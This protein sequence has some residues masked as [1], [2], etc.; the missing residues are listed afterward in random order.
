MA[1]STR[2]K[3]ISIAAGA[4]SI[5]LVAPFVS[6]STSDLPAAHAQTVATQASDFD[7]PEEVNFWDTDSVQLKDLALNPGDKVET[8]YSWTTV[9]TYR[10]KVTADELGVLTVGRPS[11][12]LAFSSKVGKTVEIPVKVTPI[13]GDPYEATLKIAVKDEKPAEETTTSESSEPEAPADPSAAPSEPS[14]APSEPSAA[15]S[16]SSEPEAPAESEGPSTSEKAPAPE[17]PKLDFDKTY[18][19]EN[20]WNKETVAVPDAKLQP[21]DKIAST[22]WDSTT[23]WPVEVDAEGNV[24]IGKPWNKITFNNAIKAGS[25]DIPVT[26]TPKEGEPYS[27]TLKVKLTDTMPP[28]EWEGDLPDFSKIYSV[29]FEKQ[30]V[31][32]VPGLTLPTNVTIE[33]SGAKYPLWSFTNVNGEVQVNAPATFTPGVFDLPVKISDGTSTVE[34]TIRINATNPQT[35]GG[36]IAKGIGG[37]LGPILGGLIGGGT[38]GLG[39]TLGNLLGGLLGGGSGGSGGSGDGKGGSGGGLLGNLKGMLDG[40]IKIE[41]GAFRF[42]NNGNNNGNN[43]GQVTVTNNA[44]PTVNISDNGS[45]NGN[46]QVSVVVT[47]NAKVNDSGNNNGNP[48]VVVTGNANP[49]VNISDNGS[50]N[51]NPNVVVTNN[52]NPTV[53]VSDNANNNG[54]PDVKISDNAKATVVVTNNANPTVNVSDNGNNNGNPVIT[55][56]ANPNVQG[57]PLSSGG[58]S[59]KRGQQGGEGQGKSG[60]SKG[61]GGSSN[62]NARVGTEGGSSDPR[63]IATLVGLGIPLLAIVPVVLSSQLGINV[64]GVDKNAIDRTIRDTARSLNMDASTLTAVGGGLVGVVVTLLAIAGLRSC[65]P[66]V[67]DVDI[68]VGS[69]GNQGQQPT[70]SVTTTAPVVPTTPAK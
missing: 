44:N 10:W 33:R 36:E 31:K 41:N 15:P 3:R 28:A 11:D 54:S 64:P 43:N 5:A 25:A 37:V 21:G 8:Y 50:N 48:N 17:A 2:S 7:T 16:E 63:C 56:N 24:T 60:S 29:D 53:N 32:P 20:F 22:Y 70:S 1:Y 66:S 23:R 19:A 9:G 49:T 47:D 14:E 39:G 38:G 51:G 69:S 4:L 35:T 45:N 6:V 67:K 40:L 65:V 34:R 52:A 12:G 13:A 59:S 30:R 62:L 61:D 57:L 18:E 55:N 42:E 26:I 46:P 27:G 68:T 58:G